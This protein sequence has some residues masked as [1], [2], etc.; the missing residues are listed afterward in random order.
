MYKIWEIAEK[1]KKDVDRSLL[2]SKMKKSL[3]LAKYTEKFVFIIKAKSSPSTSV[4]IFYNISQILKTKFY[5]FWTQ[6]C[7]NWTKFFT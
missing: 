3:I 7:R 5:A 1:I 4:F 2:V 6:T